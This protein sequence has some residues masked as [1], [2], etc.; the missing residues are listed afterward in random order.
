LEALSI[1]SLLL[2]GA[3]AAS[4]QAVAKKPNILFIMGD[5]LGWFNIGATFKA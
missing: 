5:D 4:A 3:T 1:A 2:A